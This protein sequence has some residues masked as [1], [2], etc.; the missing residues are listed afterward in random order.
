MKDTGNILLKILGRFPIALFFIF[1]FLLFTG[2]IVEGDFFWH[3]KTGEWIW[4]NRTL[5]DID[6]F[7]YTT[8]PENPFRPDTVRVQFI[9][10]QY[11]LSQVIFYWIW[12]L[13]GPAGIILLRAIIYTLLIVF[14]FF[15]TRKNSSLFVAFILTF[16]FANLLRE[17]PNERPQLFTFLFTPIAIYLLEHKS[18]KSYVFLPLLMLF[19]ANLHGGYLLGIGIILVYAVG[20]GITSL[21]RG[22]KINIRFLVI[23]AISIFITLLN[24]NTYMAFLALLQTMPSY[25]KGI[26]EYLS[27]ITAALKLREYYL[28]YFVF[29]I[30]SLIILI[31]NFRKMELTHFM[32]LLL[33]GGLSLTGLR[34]MPYFLM[35]APILSGYIRWS[36]IYRGEKDSLIDKAGIFLIL[37][38]WI[39]FINKGDILRMKIDEGFPEKSVEFIKKESPSGR[40]FNFYHWGG[41]IIYFL[42]EYK[43]FID[44]RVL[45]EEVDTLYKA[46]LWG[47][48]WKSI[49]EA[50]NI[51]MVLIPG[52]SP[53]SGEIF[54]LIFHLMMD[55]EWF[56]VY[57][58]DWSLVFVKNVDKNHEVIKKFAMKKELVYDQIIASATIL[59]KKYPQKPGFWRAKAEAERAREVIKIDIY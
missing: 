37:I 2:P 31:I 1:T 22:L 34:F 30:V 15:W 9:L 16:L 14:V 38:V 11:W 24:P 4:Q 51:N 23:C 41:Y 6:P 17:F 27:P 32:L 43:V 46:V 26:H 47:N 8:T 45:I 44:G 19:W 42:P 13:S 28:P 53:I 18:Y 40:L 5:P 33:L 39:I 36:E 52:M 54:P 57:K 55:N 35:T 20:E 25:T 7:S 3:L 49:F 29:L 10:K 12:E 59:L 58:D 50:Y 56:L 48:D 21:R